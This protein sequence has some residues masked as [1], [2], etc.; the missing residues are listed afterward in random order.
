MP[1]ETIGYDGSGGPLSLQAPEP[2]HS[3]LAPPKLER[4]SPPEGSGQYAGW[5][6]ARGS[7]K[8][9]EGS[10][11]QQQHEYAFVPISHR[12]PD[13]PPHYHGGEEHAPAQYAHY[14]HHGGYAHSVVPVSQTYSTTTPH[15]YPSTAPH[16]GP[17]GHYPQHSNTSSV[18]HAGYPPPHDASQRPQYGYYTAYPPHQPMPPP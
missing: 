9:H 17:V 15:A 5:S 1:S 11:T 2:R 14:S 3:A 10:H 18:H 16:Y 6:A 4:H 13:P 7:L 8:E 12:P